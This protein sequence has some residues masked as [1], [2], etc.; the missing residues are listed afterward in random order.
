MNTLPM[1]PGMETGR[2]SCSDALKWTIRRKSTFLAITERP[3]LQTISKSDVW[4]KQATLGTQV[5]HP[6]IRLD[7]WP[8]CRITLQLN[9]VHLSYKMQQSL[10]FPAFLPCNASSA[11]TPSQVVCRLLWFVVKV[12][13]RA[14]TYILVSNMYH[15]VHRGKIYI[16]TPEVVEVHR[17]FLH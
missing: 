3:Y 1:A 8:S 5:Q 11:C 6:V 12:R 10:L 14:A 2:T 15:R 9:E 16:A 7:F 4:L 17:K 13:T